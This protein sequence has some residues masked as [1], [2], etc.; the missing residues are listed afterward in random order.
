MTRL[1][2]FN[3]DKTWIANILFRSQPT[4]LATLDWNALDAQRHLGQFRLVWFRSENEAEI[5]LSNLVEEKT[6]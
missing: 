6:D 2:R 1:K 4:S 5:A 3:S